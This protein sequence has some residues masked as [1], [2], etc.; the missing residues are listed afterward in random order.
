MRTS[1]YLILLMIRTYFPVKTYELN[2]GM[3]PDYNTIDKTHLTAR[4]T[5]HHILVDPCIFP[6]KCTAL[7]SFL[8]YTV[9]SNQV[10]HLTICFGEK[11]K[12]LF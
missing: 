11:R 12:K 4:L 9:C 1:K 10:P 6:D 3:H 5:A 7:P 8:L 2:R